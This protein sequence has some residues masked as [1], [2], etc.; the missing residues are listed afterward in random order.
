L[1][2]LVYQMFLRKE[3]PENTLLGIMVKNLNL[4]YT[5][6]E[7]NAD[8]PESAIDNTVWTEFGISF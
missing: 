4:K 5:R 6:S 2:R 1:N 8:D 7:W 3:F